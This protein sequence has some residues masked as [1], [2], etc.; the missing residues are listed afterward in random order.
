MLSVLW[1]RFNR[2][3]GLFVVI[4][5]QHNEM[6]DEP[7]YRREH[8]AMPQCTFQYVSNSTTA[9]CGFSATARISGWS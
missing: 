1:N 9:S 2:Q 8:R 3:L 6:I 5:T 4:L 7:R